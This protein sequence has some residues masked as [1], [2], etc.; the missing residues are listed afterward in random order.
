MKLWNSI[1]SY[2]YSFMYDNYIGLIGVDYFSEIYIKA[3]CDT[4]AKTR[5]R[6]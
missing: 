1:S 5:R 3:F 2:I 4:I 6:M